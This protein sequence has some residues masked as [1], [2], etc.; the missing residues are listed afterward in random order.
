MKTLALVGGLGAA[1]LLAGCDGAPVVRPAQV[2][3]YTPQYAAAMSQ[4]EF[5][6]TAGS[7]EATQILA[8]A[9]AKGISQGSMAGPQF[10]LRPRQPEEQEL[11]TRVVVVVGGASGATLCAAPPEQG[12]E[13]KGGSLH[14]TA[15]ACT[16]GSRLTSTS[17]SVSGV[18]GP[19]DPAVAHLFRQIGAELFPMKNVNYEDHDRGNDWND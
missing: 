16:G 7:P 18:S 8:D 6:G 3:S 5:I 1:V 15:A 17:G 10:T 9:A 14:V 11:S 4:L 12:G 2:D 19:D 13:F